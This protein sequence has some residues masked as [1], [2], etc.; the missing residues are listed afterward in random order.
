MVVIVVNATI[1]ALAKGSGHL[2]GLNRLF[3]HTPALKFEIFRG[4]YWYMYTN[5]LIELHWHFNSFTM[6][7]NYPH[8]MNK[9]GTN[10]ISCDIH[11]ETLHL[12]N[13]KM[14]GNGESAE[15]SQE[16]RSFSVADGSY[17][18]KKWPKWREAQI[19]L[20]SIHSMI[21]TFMAAGLIPA[22]E[23]MAEEYGITVQQTSYLTS[24]QV[25]LLS[26]SCC[27]ILKWLAF[28]CRYLLLVML[29]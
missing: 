26:C 17:N 29:V 7:K 24:S 28:K 19:W 14:S 2:R 20:I 12:E 1:T 8:E 23:S 27:F 10:D 25:M 6:A 3:S 18:P 11:E 4:S 5:G 15:C 21:S 22:Y 13:V 16:D 9:L